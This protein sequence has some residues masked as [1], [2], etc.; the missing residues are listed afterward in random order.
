MYINSP[1]PA[2]QSTMGSDVQPQSYPRSRPKTRRAR[3][4]PSVKAPY[5]SKEMLFL[6]LTDSGMKVRAIAI[7]IRPM[8]RLIRK[9][10]R[11]PKISMSGP[12]MRGP[13]TMARAKA[14]DQIPSAWAR[15]LPLLKFTAMIAMAVG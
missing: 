15:S 8:G 11:Q 13:N 2:K 3:E 10:D 12:P 14:E 4:V 1:D 5:Q 9:T 6:S 7:P